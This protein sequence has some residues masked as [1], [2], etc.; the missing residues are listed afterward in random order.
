MKHMGV[1]D[2]W[3]SSMAQTI[4]ISFLSFGRFDNKKNDM[5]EGGLSLFIRGGEGGGG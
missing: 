1:N 4:Q 2:N 5:G 3:W